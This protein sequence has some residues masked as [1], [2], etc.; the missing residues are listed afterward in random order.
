M[1]ATSVRGVYSTQK[2]FLVL[3]ISVKLDFIFS[4][5]FRLRDEDEIN[6]IIIG[7][8]NHVIST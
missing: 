2:Q 3:E 1:Y 8:E 5:I 6:E 7:D 4:D